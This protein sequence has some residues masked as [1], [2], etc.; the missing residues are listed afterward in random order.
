[1][2]RYRGRRAETSEILAAHQLTRFGRYRP[3]TCAIAKICQTSY[4]R[5]S[6]LVARIAW[7]SLKT[8]FLI[9]PNMNG[10]IELSGEANPLELQTL[11]QVLT[12]ASSNNQQ[13]VKTGTQQLQNWE[14]QPGFYSSL[15]V[16]IIIIGMG[17]S[18]SIWQL[19]CTTVHLY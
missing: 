14:R 13:Q 9:S 1:M 17:D 11:Y 19:T 7:Q 16:G 8:I 6:S 10:A 4:K 18:R 3:L 15:Q 2:P 12:S 5:A